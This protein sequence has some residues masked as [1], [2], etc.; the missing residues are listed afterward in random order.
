M[1]DCVSG[2]E[3]SGN[4]FYKV[5]R[6]AFLGGGRDHQVRNNIFVDCNYAVELEGRGLDPSPVWHGMV[7]QTMRESPVSI[8]V[9]L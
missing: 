4:V 9:L 1:D 8:T 6:A 7:D 5:Q 3:I 2:T